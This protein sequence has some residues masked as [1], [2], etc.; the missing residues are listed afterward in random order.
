M[1]SYEEKDSNLMGRKVSRREA[2]GKVAAVGAVVGVGIVAGVGGYLAGGQTAPQPKTVT[3]TVTAAGGTIT[4]TVTAGGETVT[5]TVTQT[6]TQTPEIKAVEYPIGMITPLSGVLADFGAEQRDAGQ[7]GIDEMN[8]ML[9]QSGSNV[10]FRVIA[11]DDKSTPEEA[12]KAVTTLR[13]THGVQVIIGPPT[14]GSTLAIKSYVDTHN[15]AVIT[16]TASSAALSTKDNIFRMW[17]SDRL[18]GKAMADLARALGVEKAVIVYRDDPYGRGIRD[19]FSEIFRGETSDVRITPGQPDYA[20]EVAA[21]ARAAEAYGLDKKTAVVLVIWEAEWVNFLSHIL[22]E[23]PSMADVTWLASDAITNPGILPPKSSPEFANFLI[24]V[25]AV[26]TTAHFTGNPIGTRVL[27]QLKAKR[28]GAPSI[29]ALYMYDAA[30]VAMLSV[31]TAGKYDGKAIINVIPSVAAHYNGASGPKVLDDVGDLAAQDYDIVA[32][33][34][35]D[36][37]YKWES[38]GIWSSS[39]GVSLK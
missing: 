18:Q 4:Q 9:G 28:G 11:V 34:K 37:S 39:T 31:L 27:E 7:L 23:F 8:S 3:Q 32:L 30:W 10:R 13:E 33:K 20:S 22:T 26:G 17:A 5:K 16:S 2:V 14:S 15:V 19:I 12:L 21:M 24:G 36:D 1:S 6:V 25:G 35:T 38:V 29:E